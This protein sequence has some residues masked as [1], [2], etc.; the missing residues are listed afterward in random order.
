[1]SEVARGQWGSRVGFL[2]A[3]AGCAALLPVSTGWASSM[4]PHSLAPIGLERD[5]ALAIGLVNHVFEDAE[6]QDRTRAIAARTHALYEQ[7]LRAH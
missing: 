4:R 5:E 1:M 2:L 3:A 6:L 7:V